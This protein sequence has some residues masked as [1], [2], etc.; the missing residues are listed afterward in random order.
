MHKIYVVQTICQKLQWVILLLHICKR[1]NQPLGS[2]FRFRQW[3][4]EV[5]CSVLIRN[6]QFLLLFDVRVQIVI[7]DKRDI[8]KRQLRFELM[9][10]WTT[11]IFVGMRYCYLMLDYINDNIDF[12]LL[13]LSDLD[14]FSFWTIYVRQ[15]LDNCVFWNINKFLELLPFCWCNSGERLIKDRLFRF[16]RECL[17]RFNTVN[18]QIQLFIFDSRLFNNGFQ[19]NNSVY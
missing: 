3:N 11:S 4:K 17:G 1:I 5:H 9:D 12:N 14:F 8:F 19:N 18:R 2:L 13:P 16:F 6:I 15:I 7:Q 10:S